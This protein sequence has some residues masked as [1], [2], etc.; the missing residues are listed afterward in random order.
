LDTSDGL[1]L[2]TN[3]NTAINDIL[4][5][6]QTNVE[7]KNILTLLIFVELVWLSFLV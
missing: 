6:D 5:I 3:A 1:A 7:I 2:A 4:D